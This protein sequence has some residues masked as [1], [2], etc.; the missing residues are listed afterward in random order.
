MRQI[1]LV[2][3]LPIYFNQ[4]WASDFGY[5]SEPDAAIDLGFHILT[6]EL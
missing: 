3:Y 1:V 6:M 4:S 2:Q 5:Q